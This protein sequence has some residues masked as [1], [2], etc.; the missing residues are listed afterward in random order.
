MLASCSRFRRALVLAAALLAAGPCGAIS[1]GNF[2]WS[3]LDKDG[4]QDAGEPGF[5]GVT[6]QLW[7]STKTMLLDSDVS[8]ST[9]VAVELWN[10]AKTSRLD[11]AVTSPA[12]IYSLQAPGPGDDRI[13][14]IRPLVTDGFSPKQ[15]GGSQTA[16]S[17]INPAGADFG[18]S[19]VFAIADNVISITSRDAGLVYSGAH[20]VT[21]L[22]LIALEPN[23]ANWTLRFTGPSGGT[24]QAEQSTNL[25]TWSATGGTFVTASTTAFTV[26][27]GSAATRRYY[28]IR[29]VE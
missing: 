14:V 12:G 1:I 25:Q 16:D 11:E 6:V 13:R 3:D 19:D 4:I 8:S 21:P 23:G 5:S 17:D 18:F 24:Y 26:I 7:N 22:R 28:R 29:R 27:T 2:I 9:G 10:S 15:A 20:A